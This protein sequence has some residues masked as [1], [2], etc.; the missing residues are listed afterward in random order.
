MLKMQIWFKQ[1]SVYSDDLHQGFPMGPCA[2]LESRLDHQSNVL[3][4]WGNGG[5]KYLFWGPAL[6]Q[7]IKQE[8]NLQCLPF[9]SLNFFWLL[10][11]L[12]PSRFLQD[13]LFHLPPIRP[14]LQF[15]LEKKLRCSMFQISLHLS[16]SALPHFSSCV[17]DFSLAISTWESHPG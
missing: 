4:V 5:Q 2:D 11:S 15:L 16:H 9:P 3:K 10:A 17:P 6:G 7:T 1:I 8:I 14:R 13:L 12:S